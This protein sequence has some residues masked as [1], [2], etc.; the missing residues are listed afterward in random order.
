MCCSDDPYFCTLA[1]MQS[2]ELAKTEYEP[3]ADLWGA[4]KPLNEITQQ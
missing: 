2:T 4:I 1:A 3:A